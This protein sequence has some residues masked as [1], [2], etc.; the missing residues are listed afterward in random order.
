MKRLIDDIQSVYKL[1]LRLDFA[2]SETRMVELVDQVVAELS[3]ILEDKRIRLDRKILLSDGDDTV[4]TCDPLRIRQVLVNLVRNSVDFVPATT[5]MIT[6][7]VEDKASLQMNRPDDILVSV[8]DNGPGIPADKQD[9]LFRKFYQA[10]PTVT[11]THGGTGLGLTIC[12]EI[13]ERHGGRIWYD[14]MH[15]EGACFRFV[16]PREPIARQVKNSAA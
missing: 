4:V 1:D 5:G 6:I 16:L 14:S 15:N 2:F 10:S 11:R 13:V 9:G 12:K 3:S 8:T 7:T